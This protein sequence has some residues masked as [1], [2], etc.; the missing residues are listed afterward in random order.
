MAFACATFRRH[1]F[2]SN[3]G[4]QRI[5]IK[6]ELQPRSIPLLL[7][8][9]GG[10]LFIAVFITL[11][12]F[13]RPYHP[14]R[15]SISTLEVT[16]LGPVQ[17]ANFF[18]FGALLCLFAWALRRELQSGW[19]AWAIPFF[20]VL[21]GI[22]VMGDGF[23]LWPTPR[24]MIFALIAFNAALCVLFLFAWRVR[25]DIRWR[26]WATG[27]VLCAVGM[28]AFLFCFGMMNHLGGPAGLMEKLATAV[29]T[30]WSV[31]LVARLLSG[32]SLVPM[33]RIALAKSN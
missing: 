18:V 32:A 28:M 19:S 23:F 7:A 5:M 14:L 13:A 3:S 12:F 1:V 15:D 17:Q 26:G 27:S 4:N 2:L 16:P 22:G 21:S 31:A 9:C 20:Q 24:H 33:E 30:L 8:G 11:G 25:G 6:N 10:L 29:R